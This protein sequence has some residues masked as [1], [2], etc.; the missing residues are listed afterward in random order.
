ML[1]LLLKKLKL[2]AKN[3]AIKDRKRMYNDTF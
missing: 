3:R 2:I 1:N